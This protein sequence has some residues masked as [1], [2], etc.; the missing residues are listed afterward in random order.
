MWS[1]FFSCVGIADTGSGSGLWA[2]NATIYLHSEEIVGMDTMGCGGDSAGSAGANSGLN[3]GS[4]ISS[5]LNGLLLVLHG[6]RGPWA[7]GRG[8]AGSGDSVETMADITLVTNYATIGLR[9][10]N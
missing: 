10:Q 3:S 2:F 1:S 5:D 4:V 9:V 8:S 6:A 7:T